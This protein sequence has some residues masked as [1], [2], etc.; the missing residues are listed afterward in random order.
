LTG[1]TVWQTAVMSDT[2]Q[3]PPATN[4]LVQPGP[5]ITIRAFNPNDWP[6]VWSVLEPI[7]RGGEAYAFARD[8]SED[9]MRAIWVQLPAATF[10][11]CDAKGDVLG[12][13]FIKPNQPG[14]GSHVSNCGYATAAQAQG[15]GVASAMCEHSQQQALTMGFRAMQFNF[16]VTS[17]EGAVR[18]WKK[19]GFNVVGTVPQAFQHHRLGLV[20]VLVMH[21]FLS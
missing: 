5:D 4:A 3:H 13:Y 17:N 1:T 21:K 2:F 20:D 12:S 15:R 18:L 14:L 11:A 8:L 16:V 7:V 19:H 6:A 9:E 10:V